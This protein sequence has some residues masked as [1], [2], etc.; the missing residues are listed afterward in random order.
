MRKICPSKVLVVKN[1]K[2]KTLYTHDSPFEFTLPPKTKQTYA[3]YW[4]LP[5][6]VTE[7]DEE[8]HG[9]CCQHSHSFLNIWLI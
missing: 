2:R 5:P 7:M 1:E 6:L 4:T 8:S 3:Y 9:Q